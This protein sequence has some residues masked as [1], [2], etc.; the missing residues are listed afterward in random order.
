LVVLAI[1]LVAVVLVPTTMAVVSLAGRSDIP[2]PAERPSAGQH[3][4]PIAQW[5]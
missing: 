3:H 1:A 5:A 2:I 4:G